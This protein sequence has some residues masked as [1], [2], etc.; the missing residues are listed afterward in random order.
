MNLSTTQIKEGMRLCVVRD[1]RYK[2]D[3]TSVSFFIPLSLKASALAFVL[4][5]LL[6]DVCAECPGLQEMNRALDALYDADVEAYAAKEGE[7][8]AAEFSLS[9]LCGRYSLD[10]TDV[11]GGSLRLLLHLITDPLLKD[12]LF[13]ETEV[14]RS[15]RRSVNTILS[16]ENDKPFFAVSRCVE[17][18]CEGEP[19]SVSDGGLIREINAITPA[20]LTEFY[21]NTLLRSPCDIVCACGEDDDSPERFASELAKLCAPRTFDYSP[22]MATRDLSRFTEKTRS[23]QSVLCI[24]FRT[25][26][27]TTSAEKLAMSLFVTLFSSSPSCRLF[28]G[29]REKLGLC[30][31]CKLTA[32][33]DKGVAVIS[34]GIDA[35]NAE[36]CREEIMRQLSDVADG[37]ISDE[38]L[39]SARRLVRYSFR[40][41]VDTPASVC[42][43]YSKRTLNGL[44]SDIPALTELT[45]TITKEQISSIARGFSA[46]LIYLLA[47]SD[48]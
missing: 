14:E 4:C 24:G 8:L 26:R 33:T 23:E 34:C 6:P 18:M 15:K 22:V 19:Y 2:T 1:G 25:P 31:F 11:R 16:G 5:E 45:G 46:E 28:S 36:S 48:E 47:A 39:G 29:V 13:D 40:T 7:R 21:Y 32:D 10:G 43:W 41:L 30:Y 12:G 20:S 38:E 9:A 42:E 17:L 35:Q 37:N 27:L 44:D 3:Y